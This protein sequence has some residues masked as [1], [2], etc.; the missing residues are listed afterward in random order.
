[1]ASFEITAIPTPGLGDTSFVLHHDGL[2]IVVDPQRDV[3]RFVA[4]LGDDTLA[5]TVDTHVHNDYISG[6]KLLVDAAGGDLVLPAAAGAS[7]RFRPAFHGERLDFGSLKVEPIHTPGHTPEHTS[8]LVLIDDVPMAV[9]TGGSMLVGSAGRSDLLGLDRAEQLGRLQYGSLMRL[10][11]LPDDVT[12]YPTHGG[13]SFCSSTIATSTTTTI[14]AERASNP[15]AAHDTAE[16]YVAEQ[17]AGLQPY[18]SYYPFMAPINVAGPEP[19][20]LASPPELE[21]ADIAELEPSVHIVDTRPRTDF[22]AGHIPGS[23]GIELTEDFCTWFGWMIPFGEP[24]ALIVET[25]ELLDEAL[26]DLARIGYENVV[27]VMWGLDAWVAEQRPVES[28]RVMTAREF[29][30]MDDPSAQVLDVRAPAEWDDLSLA[31]AEF[32]YVP[33][34]KDGMPDGLDRSKPVYIGCTTGHRAGIAAAMLHRE[35]YEPVILNGASLLGVAMM[36]QA[37]AVG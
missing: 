27:G 24:F 18:P 8:Y 6:A 21:A 30:E 32:C 25:Q 37:V 4:A 28:H 23:W 14:G 7:Y 29:V 5:A 31:D 22:A 9:F 35:G 26:R 1:M 33:Q 34:L 16:S 19:M 11:E 15:V 20:R 12:V 13:G 17:L 3:E 2:A 10:L 36:K